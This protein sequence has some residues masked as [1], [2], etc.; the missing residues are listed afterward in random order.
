VWTSQAHKQKKTE[1]NYPER[2]QNTVPFTDTFTFPQLNSTCL[3]HNRTVPCV[4]RY[5]LSHGTTMMLNDMELSLSLL[6]HIR[7]D[8][9][10]VF[11]ETLSLIFLVGNIES[12]DKVAGRN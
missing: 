6:D 4:E 5:C 7:K 1:G 10:L 12:H 8:A 2:I 9:L 3:T 11:R